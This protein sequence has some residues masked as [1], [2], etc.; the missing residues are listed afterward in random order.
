[1]IKPR[2]RRALFFAA[3][4]LLLGCNDA[5]PSPPAASDFNLYPA[6]QLITWAVAIFW[7]FDSGYSVEAKYDTP[8]NPI[9]SKTITVKDLNLGQA[10]GTAL[11]RVKDD[12]GHR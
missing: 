6:L 9:G 11:Q 10:I 4:V 3:P 2:N 5:E 1:M 12:S 8:N 7:R